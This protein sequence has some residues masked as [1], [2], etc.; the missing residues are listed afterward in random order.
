M[1]ITSSIFDAII[2]TSQDCVFWKDKER[3]FVGVNQ[4]FLDFYGFASADVLIGKTDEDMGWHNDP[5]PYKQDEL[6]VLRGESTYKVPGKCIIRGEERDIIA[7]KRPIY[8]NGKIIGLV[9]S[10]LD[11]TDVVRRRTDYNRAQILYSVAGLRKYP[12]FDTLLDEIRLEELLDPLTG[13]ISRAYILDFAKSLMDAGTP[14]TFVILDLD[15]FKYFNDTLG[16]HAGDK[17]LMNVSRELA[18]YTSGFGIVGRFGGDELLIINL[19]DLGYEDKK[20]FFREIYEKQG[21]LRKTMYLENQE[22]FITATSGCATFPNDTSEYDELFILMDKALYRGKKKGRNCYIIYSDAKY[23]DLEID[24]MVRHGIYTNMS[25]MNEELEKAVE[26]DDKLKAVF[27][28]LQNEMNITDLYYVDQAR[29]LHSVMKPELREAVDDIDALMEDDLYY[30]NDPERIKEKSPI[31]YE[32]LKTYKFEAIMIV[33]IGTNGTT[34]GYLMCAE[35]KSKRIWQEDE[36]GILYFLS[37]FLAV[38]IR[39]ED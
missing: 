3:R 16:H 39:L 23:K 20:R 10:F 2:N 1:E 22:L 34:S 12:F 29:V 14:F 7:S 13:V 4:A 21:I 37:K 31:L 35:P 11:V 36:Q 27:P 18:D 26:F 25:R 19:R 33:R 8:E 6:R 38:H 32:V 5:E 17:V 9:G 24:H 15:N 28:L 30:D